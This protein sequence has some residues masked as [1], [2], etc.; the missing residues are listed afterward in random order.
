M[1][2]REENAMMS[3]SIILVAD[4]STFARRLLKDTITK[5]GRDLDINFKF[6]EAC[7]GN[8]AVNMY[9]KYSPRLVFMDI[10]MPQKNGLAAL[11]EIK[12]FDHHACVVMCSSM[13][14]KAYIN[15]AIDQG[16]ID[17]IVKPYN[18]KHGRFAQILKGYL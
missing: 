17:F 18:D 8:D 12:E 6:I 9:K 10:I 7:N 3:A 11:K 1:R 16:I 15:E 13:G 14:Q 2:L 4:D 5:V